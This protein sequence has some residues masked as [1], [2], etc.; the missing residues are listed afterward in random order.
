MRALARLAT[1]RHG[2]GWIR[3]ER[4]RKGKEKSGVGNTGIRTATALSGNAL[5][6]YGNGRNGGGKASRRTAEA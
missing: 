3:W 5:A 2:V 4:N 1:P 6:L